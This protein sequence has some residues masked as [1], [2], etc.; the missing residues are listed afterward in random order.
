MAVC[1]SVQCCY[2]PSS[3]SVIQFSSLKCLLQILSLNC[4]LKIFAFENIWDCFGYWYPS[5]NAI[6]RHFFLQ[7]FSLLLAFGSSIYTPSVDCNCWAIFWPC[8]SV[9]VLLFSS[10]VASSFLVFSLLIFGSF[11]V[12]SS[13]MFGGSFLVLPLFPLPWVTWSRRGDL[14]LAYPKLGVLPHLD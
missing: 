13:L 6:F 7:M 4:L 2:F 14:P 12:F 10:D 3:L 5:L 9:N 11:L 8:F 1:G